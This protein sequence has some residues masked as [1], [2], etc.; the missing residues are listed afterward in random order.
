MLG[1]VLTALPP[2]FPA[3]GALLIAAWLATGREPSER[4][5]V[6]ITTTA[7]ALS[8]LAVAFTCGR[9]VAHGFHPLD[10]RLGHFYR[11]GDYGYEIVFLVDG[12]SAPV[13]FVA[14]LLLLAT[15]RFSTNYLHREGGFVRFFALM[16]VF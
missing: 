10:V 8:F 12:V 6:R 2:T 15:C 16:L 14:S 1:D 13:S 5:V 11:A 4:T 3:V 7:L 9:W